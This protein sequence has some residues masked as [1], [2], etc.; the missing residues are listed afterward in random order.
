MTTEEDFIASQA[1]WNEYK[2]KEG[3]SFPETIKAVILGE[4]QKDVSSQDSR[5]NPEAFFA[6]CSDY[7][8]LV[9]SI[10]KQV[11]IVKKAQKNSER[12]AKA[13]GE[14]TLT[15]DHKI[16]FMEADMPESSKKEQ[17]NIY[18]KVCANVLAAKMTCA[19]KT[20]NE[21]YDFLKWHITQMGGKDTL[22][23]DEK[24]DQQ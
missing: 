7:P 17:L 13:I 12:I 15:Y 16:Y 5:I 4:E 23:G 22:E 6:Y 24:K 14:S 2:P 11:D 9:D 20:F 21:Y 3:K 19:Q 1:G 18:F 10:Q 8:K